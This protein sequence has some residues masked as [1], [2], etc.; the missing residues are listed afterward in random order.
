MIK[1]LPRLLCVT[2]LL[3]VSACVSIGS[4]DGPANRRFEL[5]AADGAC[6]ADTAQP[7]APIHF[8]I[9]RADSAI[10]SDRITQRLTDSGDV[11]VLAGARWVS[12]APRMLE[13]RIVRDLV[14]AQYLVQTANQRSEQG[15]KLSC[16]LRDLSLLSS[17][18]QNNAA[19]A[20]SC[21][22]KGKN[23]DH[24]FNITNWPPFEQWSMNAAITAMSQSYSLV[25][26]ELCR[27]LKA[28]G[29]Q[30]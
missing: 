9:I 11:K 8:S 18:G 29:K 15:L 17:G 7:L 25:F 21:G 14:K 13:D 24:Q 3:L 5:L 23:V 26:S 22:L 1:S 19:V 2:L 30:E 27:E 10:S 12:N 6:S 16:E 28:A 20:L 4:D